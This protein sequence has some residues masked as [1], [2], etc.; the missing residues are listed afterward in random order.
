MKIEVIPPPKCPECKSTNVF[1]HKDTITCEACRK[2]FNP[3]Y[4]EKRMDA[5]YPI[6]KGHNPKIDTGD[7]LE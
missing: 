2:E 6:G 4:G 5:K 7:Y 3:R 1:K